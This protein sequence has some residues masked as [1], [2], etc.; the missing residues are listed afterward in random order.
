MRF[1]N[2]IFFYISLLKLRFFLFLPINLM[3]K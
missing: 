1:E 3:E 2:G